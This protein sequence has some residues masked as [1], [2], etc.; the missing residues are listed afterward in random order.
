MSTYGNTDFN[1]SNFLNKYSKKIISI[2]VLLLMLIALT[3]SLIIKDPLSSTSVITS[4]T[5][6]IYA[7]LRGEKK[8]FLRVV[9]YT[10]AIFNFFTLTVYPLLF[11]PL[12]LL[13]YISKY[14]YWHRFNIH[15]PTFLVDPKTYNPLESVIVIEKN[16]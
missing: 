8:D 9:R 3:I 6:F 11:F 4:F 13:F 10:I 5:F 2:I 14:Y 7:L 1:N 15:Y 16:K 12:I